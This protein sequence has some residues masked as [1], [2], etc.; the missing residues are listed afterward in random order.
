MKPFLCKEPRVPIATDI[1]RNE[2]KPGENHQHVV[3]PYFVGALQFG[4]F[5]G[6]WL[7]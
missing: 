1:S 7:Q 4:R 5:R 6:D 2:A 3:D